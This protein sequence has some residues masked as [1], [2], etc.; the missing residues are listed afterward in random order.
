MTTHTVFKLALDA[1]E[2]DG[3]M[4]TSN[5]ANV[6]GDWFYPLEREKKKGDGTS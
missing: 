3:G 2:V 1:D 6:L 4:T 5:D